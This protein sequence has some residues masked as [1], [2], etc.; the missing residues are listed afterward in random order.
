MRELLLRRADVPE[1]VATMLAR[2]AAEIGARFRERAGYFAE[3]RA[4]EGQA[5]F[6]A[7][8]AAECAQLE[9]DMLAELRERMA[10]LS[11]EGSA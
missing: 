11:F 9:A 2:L 6:E 8:W 7:A 10:A 1:L 3:L 4:S 5:S